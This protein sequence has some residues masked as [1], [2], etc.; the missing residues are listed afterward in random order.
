MLS[1]ITEKITPGTK[2]LDSKLGVRA[3][4]FRN[5]SFILSLGGPPNETNGTVLAGS[6][7]WS[8][9]FQCEFDNYGHGVR[10]LAGINPFASAFQLPAGE[11]FVTPTMLW[12][13][14][15]NG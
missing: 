4:Q 10:A 3:S 12:V 8:G 9:S 11:T 7:A 5:P 6:L 14:S 13:W 1:P 2:V 15:T